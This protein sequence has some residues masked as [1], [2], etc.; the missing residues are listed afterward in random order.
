MS[1]TSVLIVDD[2][3]TLRAVVKAV[4]R[5]EPEIKVVGEAAN[6]VEARAF[7]KEIDPDVITLDIE[8]PGMSGLDFLEKIMT[9]RPMPVI[10]LSGTTAQGSE[11]AIT[12]LSRG[13]FHCLQKPS[14]GNIVEALSELPG[15]ILAAAKSPHARRNRVA[16]S[17][18]PVAAAPAPAV[19]MF[20]RNALIAIGS[21]TGGVDALLDV[22]DGFPENC[23]PTLIAQHM[24]EAFIQSFA[25]RLDRTV[26]P[27][28]GVARDGETVKPGQVRFAPGGGSDLCLVAHGEYRLRLQDAS[29]DQT[30]CPSVDVLMGSVARAAG[31]NAVGAILTGMGRDGAKGLLAMRQAG[32]RTFGQDEESSTVYGMP[33]IAREYGAVERQL[34][35]KHMRAG[36]LGAASRGTAADRL[37]S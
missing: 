37:A 6:A 1:R 21:S 35:L 28:V 11:S 10:M 22:L 5:K 17:S 23:P 30:H 29:P 12:A 14:S 13:A 24:P 2:S 18:V 9:L 15:L 27:S 34:P 25:A 16:P 4:L 3:P 31:R 8:M 19:H 20:R 36:I 33:R 7:I 26:R 32:A